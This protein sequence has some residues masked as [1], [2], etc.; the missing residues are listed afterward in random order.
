MGKIYSS[1]SENVED[2]ELKKSFDMRYEEWKKDPDKKMLYRGGF[3]VIFL[4]NLLWVSLTC[5][6]FG[7]NLIYYYNQNQ[8]FLFVLILLFILIVPILSIILLL[9]ACINYRRYSNY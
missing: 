2:E 6:G 7:R 3:K 8:I 5:F 4:V 1:K 9:Y